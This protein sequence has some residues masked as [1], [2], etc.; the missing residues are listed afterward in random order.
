MKSILVF[1]FLILFSIG[2][3]A[4]T[5]QEL[6]D[7][8]LELYEKGEF[9]KAI[10]L[11]EKT[12]QAVKKELGE[13]NGS[14]ITALTNL[15]SIYVQLEQFAK[16]EPI[17]IEVAEK[18]KQFYGAT[19]SIYAKSVSNLASLYYNLHQQ[20]KSEKLYQEVVEILKNVPNEPDPHYTIGLSDLIDFY[21]KT[22]QLKKAESIY[23]EMMEFQKKTLGESNPDYLNSLSGLA[24]L[25]VELTQYEKAE[26]IF[27][28]LLE[29]DKKIGGEI[30]KD[31]LSDL[32]NLA[33]LYG[34]MGQNRK[35]EPIFTKASE[36]AKKLYGENHPGYASSLDNLGGLYKSL[37]QYDKAESFILQAQEIIKNTLGENDIYYSKII[38]GLA[39][40]YQQM[41]LFKKAEILYVQ[42]KDINRNVLG[43]D[44]PEYA[45]SLNKLALLYEKMGLYEKAESCYFE[46]TKTRKTALGENHPDYAQSLYNLALLY[47]KMGRFDNA[48][49]LFLQAKDILKNSSEE[50]PKY[51]ALTL[52]S[53]AVCYQAM[54]KY[55]KAEP[56]FLQAIDIRK[57]AFGETHPDYLSSVNDLAT[58]YTALGQYEKA[59]PLFLQVKKNRQEV[60]GEKHPDYAEVLSNL[61]TLYEDM[62]LYNQAETLLLQ[63]T[64]ID[65]FLFGENHKDYASDL[66]NLASLYSNMKQYEKAEALILQAK[67]IR[68][69]LFG[70]QHL[71]YA[72]SL[73]NLAELYSQKGQFEKAEPLYKQ[74]NEIWKNTLGE[75]H[76][77]YSNG[78]NNLAALYISLG[79]FKKAEPLLLHFSKVIMQNMLSSFSILSEKEKENYLARN[80]AL[81]ELNNSFLYDYKINSRAIARNNF[82]LQLIFKSLTLTETRN[83]IKAVQQN[84]DTAVKKILKSWQTNKGILAKQYSMPLEERRTDLSS[85]ELETERLETELSRKSAIFGNQQSAIRI[86]TADVQKK[87]QQTE[88]AIEFVRFRLFDKKWTD[89]I[90]YAA[91]ILH[92]NDSVPIFVALCEEKQL[93]KYFSSTAGSSNVKA[94]YRT[95]A[96][97]ENDKQSISGD[98]LYALMWKPLM[99]YLKGVNKI[100]YS[101]AG[102]LYRIAFNALPTGDSSLLMDKFELNQYTSTRQ[103]AIP[104]EKKYNKNS[105]AIFG[106]CLFSMDSVAIVKYIPAD[107]NANTLITASKEKGNNTGGWKPLEGTANEIKS[108]SSLFVNNK[109]STNSFDQ[110]TATE[111]EFKSLSGHSPSII[112]L[113]THGFF[114]QD[115]LKKK[116]QGFAADA[117]NAFTLADDPLLR[118]GIVL[119]GA[120]R[121]W[122][123]LPPIPGREDGI[124][125][126]YEIAQMDLSNT[127]LVVLSACET[128]LGD[129]KG[130]EGVFGLQ[131]AFKLAGVKNMLLSLWKVPDGETAELMKIF[132][133][134]YLQGKTARESFAAAQKEMRRKYS[135]FYWAAFVLI[136]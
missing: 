68:K 11:A 91:Y 55:E 43:V 135:P 3:S 109:F 19:S 116:Q 98:S 54:G 45:T 32:N 105:I 82:D 1:C 52:N 93:G 106:N 88:V 30:H 120:N 107:E 16:A 77:T 133:N 4:Q 34:E 112:H 104:A 100:N 24:V 81:N 134:Y 61:S 65:K 20:T 57:K 119:S 111:E 69:K 76:P 37:G 67:D 26:L 86:S 31:Y 117:R 74:A 23:I 87:L 71:D 101:P 124:V 27:K 18:I 132:Y 2:V 90:M 53:L 70:E 62:G 64:E 58:L 47:S 73:N 13:N 41:G 56:L 131:R 96:L 63:A 42:A 12:I 89:S 125:T 113:A 48:V 9:E 59:E 75:N 80:I 49:Q 50:T 130:S 66:S 84:G 97:D 85:L 25:Y 46:S 110:E 121:V 33:V 102:L 127:D 95:D 83:T 7:Q 128:A 14:F 22:K 115:P 38:T 17:Y 10:P 15:G 44:D 8:V 122:R 92:K 136:E 118:S 39:Q 21:K 40:L 123:G 99:P 94:I 28:E 35:A 36:I 129:I 103:L 29:L 78:L 79:Q 72:I 126:A 51:F 60:L 108:I 6:N 5:W 114:L